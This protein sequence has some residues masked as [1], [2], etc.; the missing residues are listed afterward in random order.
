MKV[1]KH[2]DC[3][4]VMTPQERDHLY[5]VVEGRVNVISDEQVLQKVF[6]EIKI[7][8]AKRTQAKRKE[9]LA[10]F[11]G[12]RQLVEMEFQKDPHMAIRDVSTEFPSALLDPTD[13]ISK[14]AY[15][16]FGNDQVLTNKRSRPS[17]ALT[18][19]HS[20][21]IAKIEVSIFEDI[22]NRIN[23]NPINRQKNDFFRK[24]QWFQQ[25][26]QTMKAKVNECMQAQNFL[27]GQR[28][29]AENKPG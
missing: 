16:T 28:I 20:C 1:T 2:G 12:D 25:L 19:G 23:S 10:I 11:D 13:Y 15:Q 3:E 18:E 24:F 29:V 8:R 27:P 17:F 7:G 6:S 9:L 22:V 26:N 14:R 5:L 4:Q 21:I